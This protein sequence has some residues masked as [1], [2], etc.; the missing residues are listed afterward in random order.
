MNRTFLSSRW[1]PSPI[2]TVPAVV[3]LIG[4]S[5]TEENI[6]AR[7]AVLLLAECRTFCRGQA[8]GVSSLN[9]INLSPPG[10]FA[11]LL[12]LAAGGDYSRHVKLPSIE[13]GDKF[14]VSGNII[15]HS[16][17]KRQGKME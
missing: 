17:L 4:K 9:A 11:I 16:S 5:Y 12:H 7:A 10:L 14:M 15:P 1:K 8:A 2:F 3:F 13:E 6:P